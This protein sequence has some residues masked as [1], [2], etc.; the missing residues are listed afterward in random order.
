MIENARAR[1]VRECRSAGRPVDVSGRRRSGLAAVVG[2]DYDEIEKTVMMPLD[3]G[4]NGE[5]STTCWIGCKRWPS[6]SDAHPRI[7][8]PVSALVP[9]RPL[10]REVIPASG[11]FRWWWSRPRSLPASVRRGRSR[12]P[13]DIASG[14]EVV[15]KQLRVCWWGVSRYSP[16]CGRVADAVGV[17]IAGSFSS[18]SV[19]VGRGVRRGLDTRR[20]QSLCE[21]LAGLRVSPNSISGVTGWPVAPP[22]QM[23]TRRSPCLMRPR[24]IAGWC[25]CP[26][27]GRVGSCR[28]AGSG[29]R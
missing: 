19:V 20:R 24:R 7:V 4:A 22:R 26:A 6:G 8:P 14:I 21:D 27:D 1:P 16:G 15:Q 3:P 25:W 29:G 28:D 2:R 17:V 9:P 5:N 10:G 13:A 11:K 18:V 23:L 12:L